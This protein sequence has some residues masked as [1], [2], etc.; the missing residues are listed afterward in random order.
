MTLATNG[1][2][3]EWLP[4]ARYQIAEGVIGEVLDSETVLLDLNRG[5]YFRLNR[6]GTRLWESLEANGSLGAAEQRLH[7]EFDVEHDQL[8]REISALAEE[9]QA[10]GLITPAAR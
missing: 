7:A 1:G 6:T 9:L 10:L 4:E 2:D 3:L 8:R 5:L